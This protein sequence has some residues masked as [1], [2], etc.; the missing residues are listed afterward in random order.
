MLKNLYT[1]LTGDPNE[2]EIKRLSPVVQQINELEPV[3]QKLSDDALR[4][5]TDEFRARLND[6]L[7]EPR[8]EVAEEREQW[9]TA[10]PDDRRIVEEQVKD[11]EKKLVEAERAALD[12]ILP[13]AFA[14]VREASVRTISLRHFDVQLIGGMVLHAGKVAEMKTGEG[15]TLVATLPLYL[16]ALLG[17]GAHLVTV[18]DYLARR[19]AQW[20]GP[21]Y[22]TL[23]LTV[24]VL[25]Q[26]EK[27]ALMFDPTVKT[28]TP[29]M[30]FLRDCARQK[31][32]HADITYG[33][34]NEFG[35]DYLRDNMAW[36]LD[37]RVQ[38]ELYYAIVDEV[39]NILIDEA[40]TP[41]IISGPA[42]EASDEY[43]RLADLV[44][45]LAP[46]DYTIDQR[47]RAITLTEK[48]YDRV[49]ELLG[50]PLYNVDRPEEADPQ[51]A[52]TMHHLEA[53][54]KAEYLF[55]RD[56][57]Y[58][59]RKGQVIIVDE[60]TGRLMPGRRW[61]DGLHQAVEAKERVPIQQESVTYATITLQNYFRLYK[62]L[63][64]MTGTAKT[65]EDEFQK[66]Y[67]LDVVVI[68]PNKPMIRVDQ[69]DLVYRNEE[70]KWRAVTVE[71][72]GLYARG[73]PTLLGTAS[74]ENSERLSKRFTALKLQLYAR[75]RLLQNAIETSDALNDK[76]RTTLKPMLSRSLDDAPENFDEALSSRLFHEYD[77]RA[78]TNATRKFG[79]DARELAR[80]R[81]RVGRKD[82]AKQLGLEEKEL[83]E[84]EGIG[85]RDL[86]FA[87][88]LEERNLRLEGVDALCDEIATHP[89]DLPKIAQ[90][91]NLPLEL[92]L[93]VY[94]D[95]RLSRD[96]LGNINRV[97]IDS[98]GD[99]DEVRAEYRVRAADMDIIVKR[100]FLRD[101]DVTRLAKKLQVDVD[102]FA[103]EN[104]DALHE[105]FGVEDAAQLAE[106]LRNG[107]LHQVLNAKEHEKEAG[108]IARAGELHA[109]TLATNMA[110]RGVDIKLGGELRADTLGIVNDVLQR[111]LPERVLREVANRIL[112]ELP[113]EAQRKVDQALTELP[114]ETLRE[115]LNEL[116]E[117]ALRGVL[118]SAS[119]ETLR[120]V[121]LD[122]PGKTPR[123]M[124]HVLGCLSVKTR[125]EVLSDLPEGTL[126]EVLNSLPEEV[127]GEMNQVLYSLSP[128]ILEEL[129]RTLSG[130]VL[131]EGLSGLPTET[132]RAML[133]DLPAEML[134]EVLRDISVEA[135]REALRNLP[136][137]AL[138]KAL[139]RLATEA[140]REV[141]HEV[142]EK[143]LR[144]IFRGLSEEGLRE[145]NWVLREIDGKMLRE[146]VAA[147]PEGT[148]RDIEQSLREL[149]EQVLHDILQ[150]L[151]GKTLQ[152]ILG[153]LSAEARYAALQDIPE[154]ALRHGVRTLSE[155][156]LRDMVQ[157]SSEKV[158][159]EMLRN[160]PIETS[161]EMLYNL[162]ERAL[163]GVRQ[164]LNNLPEKI[165]NET[166]YQMPEKM[167][168][169]VLYNLSLGELHN[170]L[171]SFSEEAL[172]DAK[173]VMHT[174]PGETLRSM[175]QAAR[176]LPER[177]LSEVSQLWRDL[178]RETSREISRAL[179]SLVETV[180]RETL[181]N[182]P[183]E[184]LLEV[185]QVL[186]YES[187]E[188]ILE[189][190]SKVLPKWVSPYELTLEAK[191]HALE[192]TPKEKYYFVTEHIDQF[193]KYMHDFAQ[194]KELG[195]LRIV[196]TERHEA[197]RIDNQLRGRS[198]RQ[199]DAGSSR[200]Y[201]SLEDEIM[202]RMGGKG[203]M[204][205]VWI[206]DIPIEH[207]WVTKAIEQAQV[208]MESYNF[209]IRKHLL[210][211]DDVLNKQREII[212][213]QRYRILTK[214]DLRDDVRGWLEEEITRII[215][216]DLQTSDHGESRLLMHLDSML[217][218]FSL[219]ES[220]LW[221]P[222]SLALVQRDLE[223][224]VNAEKILDAA[225]R[226]LELHRDFL[227]DALVPEVV[228]A[229]EQQYRTSWDEIEDLAKNTLATAQQEATE[230]NRSLDARTMVQTVGG[231][232]SM[233]IE[234][235]I[236]RGA[237]IGEREIMEAV[238]R[239]FDA[240][241]VDQI[242][243][244]VVKR[245]GQ[246]FEFRW[247]PDGGLDFNQVRDD[248]AAALDEAYTRQ[249]EKHLDDIERELGERVKGGDD[250]SGARLSQ[251]LFG[252][253]HTRHTAFDQRT[254]RRIDILVPRF[255]WVHLAATKINTADRDALRGEILTYWNESLDR[256]E[257]LRG[258]AAIFNDLL[259]E[260]MLS[261]V[262]TQW[263][264]YLTAIESLR[265]G[266]G[267]QA[268]GQ[269]NPL[270]EYQRSA[271]EMFR[272]LYARIRSQVVTYVCTYQYRG[273]ARLESEVRDRESRQAIEV[274]A[275][276]QVTAARQPPT[277]QP[278]ADRRPPTAQP[279]ADRRPLTAPATADRRPPTTDRAA[280]KSQKTE[281]VRAKPEPRA[282]GTP[283]KRKLG[284]NEP[285]W[286]GSGK[287]Y[288]NCHM[289]SDGQ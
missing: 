181:N 283:T 218:G 161:R 280:Q 235:H 101:D 17:R 45:R 253:S 213:G 205:R 239:A 167:W 257:P 51:Q 77:L 117:E 97:L 153:H 63:A 155:E 76:Q 182:I 178:P 122:L 115:V 44:R 233:A 90:R 11:A 71:I 36:R 144:E 209:D 66:V 202:R 116:P 238:R 240:R 252:I 2:R 272:D 85:E 74:I 27:N 179:R 228:N 236:E 147:L 248:L 87:A 81:A 113:E 226:A 107:I 250:L 244:R 102:P 35:F 137:E 171:D 16:N 98:L 119:Q 120:E 64:G 187:P 279:T 99:A 246:P 256:L 56:K 5:K 151:S 21:I 114:E 7:A 173:Q 50:K 31:A 105:I 46:D 222:F 288:K 82:A 232:V 170:V 109:I 19:D 263:V 139:H 157:C 255:P 260:L 184:A 180:L 271:S 154:R 282:V 23:G 172:R 195:G 70:A 273:F 265:E 18:N 6:V 278:T 41:L 112:L 208:K 34:N 128:E 159:R 130:R 230:Q 93:Q 156:R 281:G 59:I 73:Q 266:I 67:G 152:Q 162:P 146:A 196:G 206:E 247:S 24:G 4:A 216:E 270:V 284:R 164:V 33:T 197:R 95:L 121:L 214:A 132:L 131:R 276:A 143:T 286:C 123:M 53:A 285:C 254:H 245:T 29:E 72:A 264:D 287:K 211:Y 135:V 9:S 78:I 186:R 212:Y 237:E 201:V 136:E 224:G 223:Q 149:P 225:Q 25:Q 69:P 150:E 275:T 22:H 183:E 165:L 168:R 10:S 203:L 75:A 126:R 55:K 88:R 48:G 42:G 289:Q 176:I 43:H 13:E 207:D 242:V 267:L 40:R 204:D 262:T 57:D 217:P 210:E 274:P 37:E 39:D 258:G 160:L 104:A 60:F 177:T 277:A 188:R 261:V 142:S 14:S 118:R 94:Q 259:R 80:V 47:T 175:G 174:L 219:N 199:G 229:F 145:V 96:E 110:G 140:L 241:V 32:Y 200:F 30:N 198:G 148:L 190:L 127:V 61:S 185:R 221:P 189:E 92:A 268:F 89:D 91:F 191:L 163:R 194:V 192:K 49:E 68:P 251:L 84:L 15:K 234:Q 3:W 249:A 20:M 215:A 166:F 12:E 83:K 124:S 125:R 158:L 141:L 138:K 62:R 193:K 1:K 58:I 65:E 79:K 54:M 269:R 111:E 26:G 106:I 8:R 38:R 134:R 133:S 129:S 52:K 108:I 86:R 243:H 227:T 220:E 100:L 28:A 103:P 169:Q 231:A